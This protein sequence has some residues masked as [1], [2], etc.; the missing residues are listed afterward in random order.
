MHKLLN[1][2]FAE[3]KIKPPMIQIGGFI[4]AQFKQSAGIAKQLLFDTQNAETGKPEKTGI[5]AEN[6][7]ENAL[8]KRIY[9]IFK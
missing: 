8:F 6:T 7:R 4:K 9:T 3:Y 2:S 1:V 5:V